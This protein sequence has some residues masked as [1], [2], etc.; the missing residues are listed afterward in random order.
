[1]GL[2]WVARDTL[3]QTV[4]VSRA[5]WARRPLA[6][7]VS[8]NIPRVYVLHEAGILIMLSL[9]KARERPSSYSPE[10]DDA[11]LTMN[12]D[13]SDD[14]EIWVDFLL[15]Y[16]YIHTRQRPDSPCRQSNVSS[17]PKETFKTHYLIYLSCLLTI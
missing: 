1:M 6:C 4:A 12:T 16:W 3:C 5:S 7:Y 10:G 17:P 13:H 2:Q 9:S 15:S 14:R 11:V 8:A